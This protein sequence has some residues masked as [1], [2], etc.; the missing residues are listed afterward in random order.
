MRKFFT[1]LAVIL[2]VTAIGIATASCNSGTGKENEPDGSKQTV[3]AS[4]TETSAHQ[5]T[6][7]T[8][9]DEQSQS[10]STDQSSEG[11]SSSED[12][13]EQPPAK[14]EAKVILLA[15][16]SNAVGQS[17]TYHLSDEQ[18]EKY[19]NGFENVK[20]FLSCNPFGGE[21]V[22]TNDFVKVTSG[23]GKYTD[24]TTYPEG[25]FGPELG[26]AEYLTET[27]PDETFYIIKDATGA[28]TLYD[29]WYSESSFGY[30]G[31]LAY[32]ENN[33]YKH[34]LD[35]IDAGMDILKEQDIDA[36]IVSLVW[37]QG[38]NDAKDYV[39]HYYTLW[40]NFMDDLNGYVDAK[41]YTNGKGISVIQGGVTEYWTN[42]EA[43]NNVK[44]LYA[45][46]HSKA[47]FVETAGEAWA[48]YDRD[49]TDYAHFDAAAMLEL[50]RRFGAK[51]T[52]AL[53]LTDEADVYTPV[54]L[55]GAG[56][57][58]DPVII[59][60]QLKYLAFARETLNDDFSGKFIKLTADIGSENSP[61]KVI[62]GTQGTLPFAGTL[63]GNGK[64][65]YVKIVSK[66][67]GGLIGTSGGA[68][69]KDLT[70]NGSVKTTVKEYH[71]GGIIGVVNYASGALTTVTGC[72]NNASVTA[73]TDS[74]QAGGIVGRC[75]G[76]LII[77]DC[78]NTG[79]IT[80][81]G[82]YA[83][84]ILAYT[85]KSDYATAEPVIT[86]DN[87]TNTGAISG[88][89]GIGGIVGLISPNMTIADVDVTRVSN[90]GEITGTEQVGGIIGRIGA[91]AFENLTI[92]YYH[93]P[94]TAGGADIVIGSD[95]N[96]N[97][98]AYS[99]A[100]CVE[101]E[102]V[103]VALKAPSCEAEGYEAHYDC[104]V[105]GRHFVNSGEG[106]RKVELDDIAIAALDHDFSGEVTYA[107]ENDG[108]YKYTA[109][110]RCDAK[111]KEAHE[112]EYDAVT[113]TCVCGTQ[114]PGHNGEK[115]EGT[116][117]TFATTGVK[118]YYYC[119]DCG[120][121]FADE[122]CTAEITDVDEW[123]VLPAQKDDTDFVSSED[124]WYLIA[125]ATD[126]AALASLVNAGTMTSGYFRLT[127]DI[128]SEDDPVNVVIG[129]YVSSTDYTKAFHGVFDGNGHE[130]YLGLTPTAEH[131]GLF[132]VASGATIKN[133]TVRGYITSTHG[134]IGGIAAYITA[135]SLVENCYNYATITSETKGTN[136][137]VGGIV[138]IVGATSSVKD[139][140]NYASVSIT[141]AKTRAGGIVGNMK[142]TEITGCVNGTSGTA[143]TVTSGTAN[144]A[145]GISGSID[146]AGAK[147]NNCINYMDV[148]GAKGV[149][150]ILGLLNPAGTYN[151][152]NNENYGTVSV[153]G[154]GALGETNQA[155]KLIGRVAG[156]K[157]NLTV[158]DCYDQGTL[159]TS[160]SDVVA[161]EGATAKGGTLTVSNTD[162]AP[163]TKTGN[164]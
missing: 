43:L 160:I 67:F 11:Q 59:D 16:Q 31:V 164:D 2:L 41:G 50:G 39:S 65:V 108:W 62:L 70:V 128:G 134:R 91:G 47:F 83:A 162:G 35:R 46:E 107:Y 38:E 119:A 90:S 142:G 29:R 130:V 149:G 25:C 123:K 150:G 18:I 113:G 153:T 1:Y 93:A 45:E 56:T 111:N 51:F 102:Y 100:E 76:S 6:T 154:G 14:T 95:G 34:F 89:K 155:G 92:T 54:T 26:L 151:F 156:Q 63:D 15:G 69:V 143:A 85:I 8:S 58:E 78:T 49:N 9:S 114:R 103:A 80:T 30:K 145:G 88:V 81:K 79:A 131:S 61:V 105:C 135:S 53:A 97:V 13:G 140:G 120:G 94:I 33:L 109:C 55:S 104:S 116:A 42:G 161:S 159:A 66:D 84:G 57:E 98:T 86:I 147:I 72:T 117:A 136:G 141:G 101:H 146:G 17:Y 96:T 148:S 118:D 5:S 3:S 129:S 28:T 48:T 24:P 37:V 121:Y 132:G 112:H 23:F 27:Y 158:V 138:G 4:D 20:I 122:E 75:Y 126:H 74:T 71:V 64:S 19:Q 144:Y 73:I 44:A 12:P 36:K 152:A 124:N 110:T 40:N 115:V 139:C 77:T 32:E 52:E 106:Y 60:D 68:T 87:C 133:V 22:L 21:P 137:D 99:V 7:E 10:D 157:I 127:A 163:A 82:N 125:N